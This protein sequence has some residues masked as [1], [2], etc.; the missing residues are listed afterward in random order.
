MGG[1]DRGQPDADVGDRVAVQRHGAGG[2]D[3]PVAGPALDL[4]VGAARARPDG[5]PDLG[6]DLAVPTA[7]S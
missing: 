3:G 5:H 4:L 2:G 1:A 6:E 7:V